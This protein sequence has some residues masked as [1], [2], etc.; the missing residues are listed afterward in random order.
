LWEAVSNAKQ[1]QEAK[2]RLQNVVLYKKEE[3]M[4]AIE[5]L[6]SELFNR[7]TPVDIVEMLGLED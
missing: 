6:R 4:A 3:R 5:A 7:P 1:L 2:V